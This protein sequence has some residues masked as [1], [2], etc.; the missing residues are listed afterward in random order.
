MYQQVLANYHI[1]DIFR[2]LIKYVSNVKF[3]QEN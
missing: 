2:I 3:S 1:H